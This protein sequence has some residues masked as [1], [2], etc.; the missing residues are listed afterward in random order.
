MK[1]TI[2]IL[3]IAL[4]L[5]FSIVPTVA[6]GYNDVYDFETSSYQVD[7]SV[8]ENNTYRVVETIDVDFY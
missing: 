8:S 1:K 2:R 5:C 6:L 3:V 4:I 7:V